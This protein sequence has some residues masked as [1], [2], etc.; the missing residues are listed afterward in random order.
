MTRRIYNSINEIRGIVVLGKMS[1]G[2]LIFT[3]TGILERVRSATTNL[4]LIFEKPIGSQ[5]L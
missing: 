3:H 4:G 2:I 1:A 5:N